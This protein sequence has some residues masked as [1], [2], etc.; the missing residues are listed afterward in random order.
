M[1]LWR[2]PDD[3]RRFKELTSGHPIIM[4]RKTYESIGRPLQ[5][6]TNIIITRNRG[7]VAPGCVVCHSYDEALSSAKNIEKQEIFVIGGEEIYIQSL[8]YA[9][10]LHL[11]LVED[12]AEGDTYFPA[13]DEF[14][15][16]KFEE[17][18]SYDGLKYTWLILE[19][20]KR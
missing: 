6:R 4:G 8:P 16:K 17:K 20:P 10:I 15:E 12:E 18:R 13:Y 7:F 1:L 3:L 5:S 19:K 14:T 9:Q 2:I 11:T